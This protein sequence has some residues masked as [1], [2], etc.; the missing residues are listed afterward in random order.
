MFSCNYPENLFDFQDRSTFYFMPF[1]SVSPV[2]TSAPTNTVPYGAFPYTGASVFTGMPLNTNQGRSLFFIQNVSPNWPLFVN[3]APSVPS[4]QAFS[5]VLN[6]APA[7]GQ[8]G[9]SFS[10][11]HYKGPIFVSGAAAV[12][13]EI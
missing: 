10:D 2:S 9:A 6:P 12:I 1:A 4:S 8:G 5:F 11:D 7:T 13:W 3:L